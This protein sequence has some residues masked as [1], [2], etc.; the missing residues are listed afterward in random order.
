MPLSALWSLIISLILL[1]LGLSLKLANTSHLLKLADKEIDSFIKQVNML[2]DKYEE[3]ISGMSQLHKAEIAKVMITYEKSM[4]IL[5]EQM[6]HYKSSH[7][8]LLG[9]GQYV[10]PSTKRLSDLGRNIT[11][12]KE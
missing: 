7:G 9:L 2:K 10:P 11:M 8:G 6:N 1:A 4:D 5:I 12:K 3:T